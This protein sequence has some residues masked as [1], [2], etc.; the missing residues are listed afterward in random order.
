M[1]GWRYHRALRPLWRRSMQRLYAQ[2]LFDPGPP[3]TNA[4]IQ[5]EYHSPLRRL[6]RADLTNAPSGM[7]AAAESWR[8][9]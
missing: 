7:E 3:Q 1:P 8:R 9:K 2:P 5:A 4:E 6:T